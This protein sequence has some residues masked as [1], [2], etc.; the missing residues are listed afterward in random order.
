[1]VDCT[2]YEIAAV[3][4]LL[5]NLDCNCDQQSLT[6]QGNVT[7]AVKVN[8][9]GSFDIIIT[10][11]QLV[12]WF[13]LGTVPRFYFLAYKDCTIK[14]STRETYIWDPNQK[15]FNLWNDLRPANN[16]DVD[17]QNYISTNLNKSFNPRTD[18]TRWTQTQLTI[19][20]C[21]KKR[22][23]WRSKV[24]GK[25]TNC[26]NKPLAGIKVQVF[27]VDL[28]DN[29]SLP[30]IPVNPAL[31]PGANSRAKGK[32]NLL[33]SAI[34]NSCGEYCVCYT[35]PQYIADD[36]DTAD[37]RVLA[38]IQ[39]KLLKVSDILFN[40][41]QNAT[42]DLKISG[43]AVDEASEFWDYDKALTTLGC[44]TPAARF[45]LT[46]E[47]LQFISHEAKIPLPHL[48]LLRQAYQVDAIFFQKLGIN[49]VGDKFFP[50]VIYGLLRT[51][52][53]GPVP[54]WARRYHGP[55]WDFTVANG[56]TQLLQTA[57]KNCIIERSLGLP[58]TPVKIKNAGWLIWFISFYYALNAPVLPGRSSRVDLLSLISSNIGSTSNFIYIC[59]AWLE[60]GLNDAFWTTVTSILGG[61]KAKL[62]REFFNLVDISGYFAP[63]IKLIL[64]N[65]ATFINSISTDAKWNLYFTTT[66][67]SPQP[68][69]IAFS[70][71]SDDVLQRAR[72]QYGSYA[73][74]IWAAGPVASFNF[75]GL[76]LT[77]VQTLQSA[78]RLSR[79]TTSVDFAILLASKEFT[80]AYSIAALQWD[81]FRARLGSIA[82]QAQ[83][84]NQALYTFTKARETTAVT[85]AIALQLAPS[86]NAPLSDVSPGYMT[87]PD[88]SVTSL[89]S[90][91][92]DMFGS[93]SSCECEGRMS[94]TSPA[95]YLYA[96]RH[97]ASN[98]T[99]AI[100]AIDSR[101]PEMRF[102]LLS[103]SN[104]YTTLPTI[105]LNIEVLEQLVAQWALLPIIPFTSRQCAKLDANE[106]QL[107]TEFTNQN[108]YD[109]FADTTLSRWPWTFPFDLGH[110]KRRLYLDSIGLSRVQISELTNLTPNEIDLSRDALDINEGQRTCITSSGGWTATDVYGVPNTSLQSVPTM[111]SA[112][113]L[114]FQELYLITQLPNI[115]SPGGQP[116]I[117][118][119]TTT[120]IILG[121]VDGTVPKATD[122]SI[123]SLCLS[124]TSAS[125]PTDD[126]LDRIH[127]FI[128]IW[129][130][131]SWPMQ[132]VDW[133]IGQFTPGTSDGIFPLTSL[134]HAELIR[135]R[136]HLEPHEVIG[137]W[138]PLDT[139]RIEL[140]FIKNKAIPSVRE[141]VFKLRD[142][143]KLSL[144]TAAKIA[145]VPE[146]LATVLIG[147][148]PDVN[149]ISPAPA[150]KLFRYG[151]LAQ[152]V[153]DL[154]PEDIK[155]Y[156]DLLQVDVF[157]SPMDTWK[158]LNDFQTLQRSG[159]TL[160]KVIALY[161]QQADAYI[162]SNQR[163]SLLAIEDLN[164]HSK[165]L[166]DMFGSLKMPFDIALSRFVPEA[167]A[168]KVSDTLS[169]YLT[170][171]PVQKNKSIADL[172]ALPNLSL[173]ILPGDD[174][175]RKTQILTAFSDQR[176]QKNIWGIL[177]ATLGMDPSVAQLISDNV[178][179]SGGTSLT[180]NFRQLCG[181]GGTGSTALAADRLGR[182][183]D[184]GIVRVDAV[185]S[186]VQIMGK[187]ILSTPGQY[188]I[189]VTANYNNAAA[190]VSVDDA[191]SGPRPVQAGVG[192]T[193]ASLT[194]QENDSLEQT[195]NVTFA[196]TTDCE[197]KIELVEPSG[198]L[199][200]MYGTRLY[201]A[202]TTGLDMPESALD[203]QEILELSGDLIKQW[204][205]QPDDIAALLTLQ[206]G[207]P[208]FPVFPPCKLSR[209]IVGPLTPPGDKQGFTDCLD[210]AR[211]IA[212]IKLTRGEGRKILYE[213]ARKSQQITPLTPASDDSVWAGLALALKIDQSSI[214]S[215]G[216]FFMISQMDIAQPVPPSP[217]P[218][219]SIAV[220]WIKLFDL[221][222]K[223]NEL[224][225]S[226]VTLVSWDSSPIPVPTTSS[227]DLVDGLQSA[228]REKLLSDRAGFEKFRAVVDRIRIMKRDVLCDFILA[229]AASQGFSWTQRVDISDYI[230][231]DIEQEPCAD[232]SR[233]RFAIA[234]VQRLITQILGQKEVPPLSPFP[235]FLNNDQEIEWSTICLYRLWEVRQK[236]LLWP[237]NWLKHG[238]HLH[239]SPE[240][241][242]LKQTLVRGD[243]TEELATEVLTS[244][245][246]ELHA[247]G[248][249]EIVGTCPQQEYDATGALS[250]DMLHVIGRTP[251][252]PRAYYYRSQ[253]DG[254]YWTPWEKLELD[255]DGDQILP[256]VAN[257]QLH[258]F[259]LVTVS[260]AQDKS[261]LKR[262]SRQ[263]GVD[264]SYLNIRLAWSVLTTKGWRG[265]M[266]SKDS[267][268]TRF[269][270]FAQNS[271]ND[272]NAGKTY[273]E[274]QAWNQASQNIGDY[275]LR[276]H[277]TDEF[278]PMIEVFSI[279]ETTAITKPIVEIADWV[280]QERKS[281]GDDGD[282]WF[283]GVSSNLSSAMNSDLSDLQTQS[284]IP[285]YFASP[286]V[287]T[288]TFEN[289]QT[290]RTNDLFL[291]GR[292]T[293]TPDNQVQVT[294]RTSAL[295]FASQGD[296]LD[297]TE[298]ARTSTPFASAVPKNGAYEF[299]T[300]VELFTSG[301][302]QTVL[303]NA[304]SNAR[305]V[306]TRQEDTPSKT[307]PV[308]CRIQ[309]KSF[310]AFKQED[311]KPAVLLPVGRYDVFLK[312]PF[313]T[314]PREYIDKVSVRP[315]AARQEMVPQPSGA[316]MS[317]SVALSNRVGY[318]SQMVTSFA[319]MNLSVDTG[320]SGKGWRFLLGHHSL[321]IEMLRATKA[322][323]DTLYNT[324][325]QK[326]P[327][328][329]TKSHNIPFIFDTDFVP[330]D[331][332]V[333][334][335]ASLGGGLF[336]HFPI[337]ELE[338]AADRLTSL[339]NWEHL[340]HAPLVVA[341]QK[342]KLR[343]FDEARQWIA[344][345][346]NPRNNLGLVDPANYWVFKPFWDFVEGNGVSDFQNLDPSNPK[347]DP[348][349]KNVFRALVRQW[350]ENPYN[351]HAVAAFRPQAYQLAAL[352]LQVEN[353]IA[354][355]DYLM[356]IPSAELVEEAARRY[357]EA[358]HIIGRAP[359]ST[360]GIRVDANAKALQ[361]VEAGL[362][363]GSVDLENY[364]DISEGPSAHVE[365]IFIPNLGLGYFCLPPNP[366]INELRR[367]IQDRLFKVH[368]CLDLLG[369]PRSLPL[370]DPPI[371]P[372][373]LADA[374]MAGI[375]VSQVVM[376]AYT[377]RPNYRSRTLITLAKSI[378]QQAMALG[379]SLL[380]A[381]EK[382]DVESLNY[383]KI[384]H[385][386]KVLE[387][388]TAVRKLQVEDAVK[389]VSALEATM[390]SVGFRRQY[391]DSREF[392]NAEEIL[393]IELSVASTITRIV[394]QAL[395]AGASAA[396]AIPDI[397]I[398]IAGFAGS[399]VTIA[400][401][402]GANASRVPAD[403][404]T[405]MSA[406]G[407][408][409][410]TL[411]GIAGSVGSFQRRKDDWEF[412]ADS[413]K[414]EEKQINE[415][416]LA[417]K[418]RQS[419]AE[420]ELSNH[421]AQLEQSR[422]ELDF[423]RTKQTAIRLYE[424]LAADIG[425]S[426]YS[427]FQLA[428]N[429]A[430]QAQRAMQDELGS[431]ERFISYSQWDSGKNGL[432]AGE[433]LMNELLEMES[434]FY[435]EN[436]RLVPKTINVSLAQ[437]DP[438]ALA[439]LKLNGTCTFALKES[440]WDKQAPGLYYR[441]YNNVAVS[442]PNITGAF[443]GVHGRV[444]IESA[445][446][447]AVPTIDSGYDSTGDDDPRFIKQFA[448]PGDV[449]TLS[450]GI[451]D[452]GL[453]S[454]EMKE[455]RYVPWQY[456]GTDSLI[457]CEI[458]QRD[459]SFD[460]SSIGDV[461]L[462]V[463]YLAREGGEELR[464]AARDSLKLRS[465]SE[466]I[467]FSIRHQFASVW[468]MFKTGLGVQ[469]NIST[470]LP[471]GEMNRNGR[472]LNIAS[473][474][475]LFKVKGAV[476]A[477][478]ID[479]N[480]TPPPALTPI[481]GST[482]LPSNEDGGFR[483]VWF[484]KSILAAPLTVNYEILGSA[485][486]SIQC[487]NFNGLDLEDAVIAINWE[488]G[489]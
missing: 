177:S 40:A 424:W 170:G 487:T 322:G 461:I 7:P 341:M 254:A 107:T 84:A 150:S 145:A 132:I 123:Y 133:A 194:I 473:V 63:A 406:V 420:K 66:S 351:P 103:H 444:F 340:Y 356:P 450:T 476:G 310:F 24:C 197:F 304:G 480:L 279:L 117:L 382:K 268:P 196:T 208:G 260:V 44:K 9:D 79:L 462:H 83:Y 234:G 405:A 142:S 402:G 296:I 436:A 10:P 8:A 54:E 248:H 173:S 89:S 60:F 81:D 413:A 318:A 378:T 251:A 190:T 166:V 469:L 220:K 415:Q 15:N 139:V 252:E 98:V 397:T 85:A 165:Y 365:D 423:V 121:G 195:L 77:P 286:A 303:E 355:G 386:S 404:S 176:W 447:R 313:Q 88:L 31:I 362:A 472:K 162:P 367:K 122:P 18:T 110:E 120:S 240:F 463:E 394:G 212:A 80:S 34:T 324:D 49:V 134:G 320:S 129:R 211:L 401:T 345:V 360:G 283:Q 58:F 384:N 200:P 277:L 429:V 293:L 443:G 12:K 232:V 400:M 435:S 156:E 28:Y 97:F 95:A 274:L 442:V 112:S 421:E 363:L 59:F 72:L 201:S 209:P 336:S 32:R 237:E 427:A 299:D 259:W 91:T 262:D 344:R 6:L 459:N 306:V 193:F 160:S 21:A 239:R 149:N 153:P 380:S 113:Q 430:L 114:S 242:E 428:Q 403:L 167:T 391:Y 266:I 4:L 311:P 338:F 37:I 116:A 174:T 267:L 100:G 57:V 186:P 36:I 141:L 192:L 464:K 11:A 270:H 226:A 258:L 17:L 204:Q 189:R 314:A 64:T 272:M 233:V 219:P 30:G 349:L 188:T 347:A 334:R 393:Q 185:S 180:A 206:E 470:L 48:S 316:T 29:V 118:R 412:Q 182:F 223:L 221:A 358:Q 255:I 126:Q 125:A 460:L 269:G 300:K 370:Y 332:W 411:S 273:I 361:D 52:I 437:V 241:E 230:I 389:A 94:V 210:Y 465:P 23:P 229:N 416:I 294:R 104:S 449:I 152:A 323:L 284:M 115:F 398:G 158:A 25:I 205:L 45:V 383:L 207:S 439:R 42:I 468:Q 337:D 183:L 467:W 295:S 157:A 124:S 235:L 250:I 46:D 352:F 326:D 453:G 301:A 481:T 308:F 392:M 488:L 75:G 409:L 199:A 348:Y 474:L 33:G 22:R 287:P 187:Y 2:C 191:V 143:K 372:A 309:N 454:D 154:A 422:D 319:R 451:K 253:V 431:T 441:R 247:L 78:V 225:I 335:G 388:A 302:Y 228:T 127:R 148:P 5:S 290:Q 35:L 71:Y 426:Y 65:P 265:K 227:P 144:A 20:L 245:A 478:D 249:L 312:K 82:V 414:L 418:I 455:D 485:P 178:N 432:Q 292:F 483:Y 135:K 342:M 55:A 111:M 86:L 246:E 327:R 136:L 101:R 399:P 217:P 47:Q 357:E 161:Y 305:V 3:P 67:V 216:D 307:D 477:G 68:T 456:L 289:S 90:Y 131:L 169:Q 171:D 387:R 325:T 99:G 264:D 215:A 371:D 87:A 373:L 486:W 330:D 214:E 62:V 179:S 440:F 271:S 434:Q 385:E 315:I 297:D 155:N 16:K 19:D 1:M 105:E 438:I 489:K 328:L 257:R 38:S 390:I 359:Q 479:F 175:L 350:R 93:G 128:R 446:Y 458:S 317:L 224:R 339:A 147:P 96:L 14:F 298:M 475:L 379:N 329:A 238:L 471:I 164:R 276:P 50:Q 137:F 275:Q 56:I 346:F 410:G 163:D 263:I 13:P 408:M 381:L 374:A 184:E 457:T 119:L 353:L 213:T 102:L 433:R 203:A 321:S 39:G 109:L 376:D 366:K 151:R 425:D 396:G 445:S 106:L 76:A 222:I 146:Q 70:D 92:G 484:Y 26:R 140:P 452:T 73:V 181:D 108:V 202:S 61:I 281:M 130:A 407:E 74:A 369:K 482:G 419:I 43:G 291:F 288:S 368:H 278:D 51:Q 218:I 343:R 280:Y 331:P 333:D 236:I 159:T 27:D 198:N 377:P 69:D 243:L 138:F 168:R 466:G 364:L 41:P 448:R 285:L 375:N 172:L 354:W 244:F 231:S 256:F 417:A 395:G 53:K 282:G 261:D